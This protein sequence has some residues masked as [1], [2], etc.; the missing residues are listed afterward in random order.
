MSDQLDIFNQPR[1]DPDANRVGKFQG[2]A[3]GAAPTQREAAILAYPRTGTQRRRIL[4][5]L[6]GAGEHG[7]TD[8]EMQKALDMNPSTQR[9][10]RVELVEGGWVERTDRRRRTSSKTPAAVWRVTNRL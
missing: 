6:I 7:A 10:R 5:F 4:D 8:E 9:P 3:A 2:P 1:S